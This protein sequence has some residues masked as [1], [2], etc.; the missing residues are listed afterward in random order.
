MWKVR[1]ILPWS[2]IHM[3][4]LKRESMHVSGHESLQNYREKH[5]NSCITHHIF[6]SYACSSFCCYL[7]AFE[8][9]KL[10][11]FGR[12]FY[13]K[14]HSGYFM[15]ICV[16]WELNPRPWRFKRHALPE[17]VLN[18]YK[19]EKQ[20]QQFLQCTVQERECIYF[21]LCWAVRNDI[22][23]T[24]LCHFRLTNIA[25]QVFIKNLKME[26]EKWLFV[27]LCCSLIILFV[28]V[29]CLPGFVITKQ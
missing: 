7:C 9:F 8:C 21:F 15:R 16:L 17:A 25:S 2:Y 18:F 23:S 12:Y 22:K 5:I 3:L 19:I 10:L 14:R 6:M 20:P 28:L 4:Y 27:C 29:I 11:L 24:V 1:I 13:P 26:S